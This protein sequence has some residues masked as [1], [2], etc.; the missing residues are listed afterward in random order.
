MDVSVHI[1]PKKVPNADYDTGCLILCG[2]VRAFFSDPAR[3]R[4]YEE[5]MQ[6]PEGAR[7]RREDE[8]RRAI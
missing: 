3:R 7:A 1:D 6:T 5:W 8:I 2:A 4:A